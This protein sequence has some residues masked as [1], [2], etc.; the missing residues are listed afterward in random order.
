VTQFGL[1]SRKAWLLTCA[2][3]KQLRRFLLSEID[4][5]L[6][7]QICYLSCET[8][9]FSSCVSGVGEE[10]KPVKD[11][12]EFSTTDYVNLLKL[13]TKKLKWGSKT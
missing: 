6:N 13:S 9:Y 12:Q 4:H 2:V 3:S 5:Q 10:K 8:K 11:K 1:D 7:G